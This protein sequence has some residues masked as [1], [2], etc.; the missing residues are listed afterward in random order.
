MSDKALKIYKKGIRILFESVNKSE[1][2]HL[3]YI[4]AL[5]PYVN[6]EYNVLCKNPDEKDLNSIEPISLKD[7]CIM[8]GFDI[9]HLNRLK[10]IYSAIRFNVDGEQRRFVAFVNDGT[11]IKRSTICI[12]PRVLYSGSDYTK[13][14]AYAL[15]F[16]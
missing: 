5:L 4:F 8:I 7:F 11:D 14:E 15:F 2:K 3:G 10:K 12:N 6:F 13:V 9:S 1:H 16:R